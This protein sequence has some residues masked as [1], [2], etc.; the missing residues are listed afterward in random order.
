MFTRQF[1]EIVTLR[2]IAKAQTEKRDDAIA[3][4]T[5]TA[6]PTPKAIAGNVFKPRTEYTPFGHVAFA[7][8][9]HQ[10]FVGRALHVCIKC[11]GIRITLEDHDVQFIFQVNSSTVSGRLRFTG[12]RVFTSWRP[13]FKPLGHR[14]VFRPNLELDYRSK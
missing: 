2:V 4:H 14:V 7:K 12:Q 5:A 1:D 3:K 6:I 9:F 11:G 10:R 13:H 8:V